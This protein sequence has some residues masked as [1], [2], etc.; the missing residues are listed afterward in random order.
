M[1]NHQKAAEE[2]IGREV[3]EETMLLIKEAQ[4]L[5]EKFAEF[6][7]EQNVTANIIS[8][9]NKANKESRNYFKL[10]TYFL[11]T[12]VNALDQIQTVA[13]KVGDKDFVKWLRNMR[14]MWE[15]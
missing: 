13:N 2:Q 10:F 9:T 14:Q 6:K 5:L 11:F 7:A 3:R 15:D 12:D 1:F 8:E 4:Q